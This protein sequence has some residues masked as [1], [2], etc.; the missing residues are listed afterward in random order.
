MCG[1]VVEVIVYIQ[2]KRMLQYKDMTIL[3][4]GSHFERKKKYRI[5]FVIKWMLSENDDVQLR[6]V[7][8]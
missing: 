4:D 1:M 8:R 3:F 7:E 6:N 2:Y 5:N